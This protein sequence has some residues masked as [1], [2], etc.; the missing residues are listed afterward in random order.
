ME[1]CMQKI[2]MI[3]QDFNPKNSNLNLDVDWSVEFYNT[4]QKRIGFDIILKSLDEFNFD[5]KIEGMVILN[6]VEEFIHN[7]LSQVIFHHA[8]TILMNMVSLTRQSHV[9]YCC[10][11]KLNAFNATSN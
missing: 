3:R 7:D 5:F 1:I 8:C 9:Q 6:E 2:A 10:D 4:D 11:S